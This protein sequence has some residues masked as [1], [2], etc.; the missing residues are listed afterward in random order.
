M[1]EVLYHASYEVV[2]DPQQSI[3]SLGYTA[4]RTVACQ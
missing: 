2:S 3:P 4:P 1:I